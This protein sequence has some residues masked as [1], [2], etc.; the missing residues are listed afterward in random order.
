[1]KAGT[2]TL[3]MPFADQW[4]LW[5]YLPSRAAPASLPVLV[6]FD[7]RMYKDTV[8]LPEI[9]DYL[10]VRGQIPPVAALMVDNLDRS[11]LLCKPEYTDFISNE[12]ISWLRARSS[13]TIDPRQTII[14]GSSYGGLATAFI[15]YRNPD[16]FGTVLSQ[17][18]W[19]RWHPEGDTQHHW[20]AR[21]FEAAPKLPVRF[22]LQVGNLEVARMLDGGPTQLEA[23]RHFHDLLHA[24]GNEV[25]YHEYSGGHDSS[26]LEFPLAQ[27]LIELFN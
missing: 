23:N 5:L 20:L 6:V 24:K 17:T 3:H 19:F 7:G 12:V 15:A 4:R 22:W 16:I 11:E 27:A 1:M 14:L 25:H 2:V 26:S 9:L 10:I 13:I 8:K 21:Q 18:G